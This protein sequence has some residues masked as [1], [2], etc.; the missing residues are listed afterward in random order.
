MLT[1]ESYFWALGKRSNSWTSPHSRVGRYQ[2][3]NSYIWVFKWKQGRYDPFSKKWCLVALQ[4]K[5]KRMLHSDQQSLNGL[6]WS[7]LDRSLISI[8]SI[9]LYSIGNIAEY[10]FSIVFLQNSKEFYSFF[11]LQ[12]TWTT[13]EKALRVLKIQYFIIGSLIKFEVDI[14]PFES[15]GKKSITEVFFPK[16]LIMFK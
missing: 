11:D 16:S 4:L 1:S 15:W 14:F 10:I 9:G 7:K 8:F 13:S 12:F 3:W 2:F 6:F 5:Q